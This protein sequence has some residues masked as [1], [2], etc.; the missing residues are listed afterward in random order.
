M[1][2][3]FTTEELPDKGREI[4][5]ASGVVVVETL[6]DRRLQ[7]RMLRDDIAELQ[8]QLQRFDANAPPEVL[9]DGE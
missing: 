5:H 6:A 7:R 8:Q 4:H 9:N 2:I 3:A 1:S